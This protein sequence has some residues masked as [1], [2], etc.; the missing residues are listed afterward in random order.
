MIGASASH[1]KSAR[2]VP[3]TPEK[4]MDA[5]TL[6]DDYCKL[7]KNSC[8]SGHIHTNQHTIYHAL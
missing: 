5:P 3:I 8:L 4:V 7:Q 2:S 1:T 6:K